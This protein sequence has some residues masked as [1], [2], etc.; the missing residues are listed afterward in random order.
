MPNT[1]K[2]LWKIST[3]KTSKCFVSFDKLATKR[4][5]L[6]LLPIAY[7]NVEFLME[8]AFDIKEHFVN[9]LNFHYSTLLQIIFSRKQ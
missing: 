9:S 1:F 7:E 6:V 2:D 8:I 4:I 5:S 3:K